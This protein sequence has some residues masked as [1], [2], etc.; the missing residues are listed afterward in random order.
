VPA[1]DGRFRPLFEKAR[2]SAAKP[3]A[4]WKVEG[5]RQG[6]AV[7]LTFTPLS[8]EA[9]ARAA[10]IKDVMFF[11]EDGFI[12]IDKGQA[13]SKTA[14]GQFALELTVSQYALHPD[15]KEMRGI[16][17]CAEG[18]SGDGAVK[19]VCFRAAVTGR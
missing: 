5:K 11:T 6:H 16:L 1:L 8:E 3:L 19:S 14:Q 15:A 12:N 9:K 18:W 7:T 13:F 17:R 2:A 10:L 4:G